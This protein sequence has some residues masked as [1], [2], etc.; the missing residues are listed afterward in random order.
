LAS[1]ATV[2]RVAFERFVVMGPDHVEPPS[3][4]YLIWYSLTFVAALRL[5]ARHFRAAAESWPEP[6]IA[7]G[8]LG[9][10]PAVAGTAEARRLAIRMIADESTSQGR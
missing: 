9:A 3:A 7:V 2:V 6:T 4:E 5:G 8:W 10:F 1:P